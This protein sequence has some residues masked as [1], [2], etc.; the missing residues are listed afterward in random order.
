[1]FDH[2]TVEDLLMRCLKSD[3]EAKSSV[4]SMEG[5]FMTTISRRYPAFLVTLLTCAVLFA[6]CGGGGTQRQYQH[7]DQR[8]LPHQR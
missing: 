3:S 6:S 4:R 8:Q 7:K 2:C 1:M 5:P